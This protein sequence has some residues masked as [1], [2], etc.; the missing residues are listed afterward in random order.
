MIL[1][2]M[3]AASP[4]VVLE[5]R[6]PLPPSFGAG[7]ADVVDEDSGDDDIRAV[8]EEEARVENCGLT[9]AVERVLGTVLAEAT[10]DEE[11]RIDSGSCVCDLLTGGTAEE[12][13]GSAAEDVAGGA[14]EEVASA[15]S[16]INRAYYA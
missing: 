5:E 7:V 6:P 1:H 15:A 11:V 2:G 13:G 16:V 12:D 9:A 4:L 14:A 8:V 3:P 10:T